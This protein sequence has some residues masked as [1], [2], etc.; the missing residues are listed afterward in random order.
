MKDDD[1]QSSFARQSG[2]ATQTLN[3]GYTAEVERG[4]AHLPIVANYRIPLQ[5]NNGK[6]LFKVNDD[7]TRS[8]GSYYI[9]SFGRFVSY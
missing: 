2:R 4:L 6:F 1:E 7:G 3:L 9:D 8:A 5:G